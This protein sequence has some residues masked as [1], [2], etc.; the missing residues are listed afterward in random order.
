MIPVIPNPKQPWKICLKQLSELD[1][2]FKQFSPIKIDEGIKFGRWYVFNQNTEI[3]IQ[4]ETYKPDN[5]F[6]GTVMGVKMK[7]LMY[8]PFFD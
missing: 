5:V 3:D 2:Y 4:N 1:G 6:I 8:L 7:I